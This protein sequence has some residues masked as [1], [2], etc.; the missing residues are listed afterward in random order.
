MSVAYPL[1]PKSAL[2]R[3]LPYPYRNAVCISNDPDFLSLETFKLLFPF[4]TST[5]HHTVFGDGLGLTIDTGFFAYSPKSN[6]LA[7]SR[8]ENGRLL[9]HPQRDQI[10]ELIQQGWLSSVHT[11]GDHD[12][13][14]LHGR[15]LTEEA[16]S[17]VLLAGGNF[18]T[19]TNHGNSRNVQ[20]IGPGGPH[21]EGDL[22]S[23]TA[24]STDL[25]VCD[26]LQFF[27]SAHLASEGSTHNI[28]CKRTDLKFP[29][30]AAHSY[31]RAR[32]SPTNLIKAVTL[33]DGRSINAFA[34]FRGTG[35]I[36]PNLS[37]LNQQMNIVLETLRKN[38]HHASIVYQH[39]GVASKVPGAGAIAADSDFLS[40]NMEVFSA[41]GELAGEVRRG[42]FW[43]PSLHHLLSYAHALNAI[44]VEVRQRI[45]FIELLLPAWLLNYSPL[46]LKALTLYAPD[47][48]DGQQVRCFVGSDE[49]ELRWNK[50]DELGRFSFNLL[51]PLQRVNGK[52]Q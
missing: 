10:V 16:I 26:E 45:G 33:R 23:S 12:S 13:G 2:I 52:R 8:Y 6:A 40:A 50:L 11:L 5:D 18:D 4:L 7:L 19:W 29:R 3:P 1:R 39:F 47:A 27:T 46:V 15:S 37:N 14:F 31:R 42:T 21:H 25:W 36:A 35:L 22:P 9:D 43:N 17:Q 38:P 41:L 48:T 20:C 28:F 24:Y 34:R 30:R 49:Y 51:Q 32:A 44:S